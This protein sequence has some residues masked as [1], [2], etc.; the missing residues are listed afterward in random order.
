M[1]EGSPASVGGNAGDH[2]SIRYSDAVENRFEWHQRWLKFV[3]LNVAESVVRQASDT[4]LKHHDE[5]VFTE[6]GINEHLGGNN[7]TK[8]VMTLQWRWAELPSS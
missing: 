5:R 6:K 3:G 2:P 1:P 7:A 8:L 4:G